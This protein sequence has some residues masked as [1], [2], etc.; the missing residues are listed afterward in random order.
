MSNGFGVEIPRVDNEEMFEHLC[1]DLV[2][3]NSKYENSNRNGRRGQRQNGVD[4]FARERESLNW[5]GI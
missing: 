5:I 2:K 4:I 3:N 1:L